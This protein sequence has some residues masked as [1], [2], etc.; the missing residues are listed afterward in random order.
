MFDTQKSCTQE[1]LNSIWIKAYTVPG[2]D[3]SR[4]RAD[5]CGAII[6]YGSRDDN[7]SDLNFCWEVDHID[8]N[9]GD[10]LS[11]LRPLQWK[12]NRSK[13]DKLPGKPFCVVTR[14]VNLNGSYSNIG[15]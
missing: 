1:E 15:C 6:E 9:R 3:P 12:N 8:P 4:Y 7:G 13:S 11:N 10:D 5:D 14:K 2:L